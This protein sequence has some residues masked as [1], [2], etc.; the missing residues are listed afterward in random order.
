[1]GGEEKLGEKK[2]LKVKDAALKKKAMSKVDEVAKLQ[3]QK[4]LI[5]EKNKLA[6]KEVGTPANSQPSKNM[7][8]SPKKAAK[9][10]KSAAKKVVKAAKKAKKAAN[11]VKKAKK[12]AKKSLKKAKKKATKKAAKKAAK[13]PK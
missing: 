8:I 9:T 7:M 11:A 6:L 2:G 10:Q 13:K 4:N 5:M 3:K 12:A 1:M